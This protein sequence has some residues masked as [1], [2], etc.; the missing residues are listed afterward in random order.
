MQDL[1]DTGIQNITMLTGDRWGVA[2]RVSDELGCTDVIA[3]CFPENKLALVEE[4]KERGLKVAVIGDG[5]NDAPA[6]AAGDLGIAMGAAGNDIAVNSATVALMNN[7]LRRLPFWYSIYNWRNCT[8][9]I[10]EI[11]S[12][13]G[14]NSALYWLT[15]C[16]L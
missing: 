11:D 2:R 4:M 10:W 12:N 7:D 9:C 1:K 5:V 8:F 13:S 15:A 3:E 16:N 6:L 14:C